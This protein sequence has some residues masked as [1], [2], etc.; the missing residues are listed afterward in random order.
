M[1]NYRPISLLSVIYK[2][3]TKIIASRVR[4]TLKLN[5]PN[6]QAEFCAGYSTIDYIHTINQ[7]T[8]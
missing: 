8:E 4:A 2:P 5:E 7:V 1:I 3:F 6:D